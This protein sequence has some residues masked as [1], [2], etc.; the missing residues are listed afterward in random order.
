MARKT[1]ID[2]DLIELLESAALTNGKS[3]ARRGDVDAQSWW[4]MCAGHLGDAVQSADS[5]GFAGIARRAI[6]LARYC[7]ETAMLYEECT[8]E[9]KISR[10]RAA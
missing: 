9:M 7:A 5:I 3:A 8:M 4:H 6:G 1:L 10:R 2:S